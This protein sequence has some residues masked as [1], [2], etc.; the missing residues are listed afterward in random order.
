VDSCGEAG[1][2]RPKEEYKKSIKD[3]PYKQEETGFS[4]VSEY[5]LQN[6]ACRG[7]LYNNKKREENQ[8]VHLPPVTYRVEAILIEIEFFQHRNRHKEGNGENRY[9]GNTENDTHDTHSLYLI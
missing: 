3:W 2:R 9:P 1:V 5:Y 4:L 7:N 6:L 8:S